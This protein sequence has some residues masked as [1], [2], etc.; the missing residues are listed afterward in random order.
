M[1][2]RTTIIIP[3]DPDKIINVLEF[4]MNIPEKH[5]ANYQANAFIPI[6]S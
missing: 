1:F 4:R 6:I 2:Y 5:F 3:N